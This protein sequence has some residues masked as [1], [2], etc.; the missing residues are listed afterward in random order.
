MTS[1]APW[2]QRLRNGLAPYAA[3]EPLAGRF[4]QRQLQAVQ[5]LTPLAMAANVLNV[6]IVAAAFRDHPRALWIAAWALL[7][8]VV[9]LR[10]VWGWWRVQRRAVR[11]SATPRALA[12]LTVHSALLAALWAPIPVLLFPGAAPD[13]Q[14]LV[15]TI[16][17]GMMCAGAFALATVPLAGL[18]YTALLGAAAVLA[19]ALSGLA[20]APAITMLLSIY[21]AIVMASV[22]STAR[23]FGARLVAE[24]EAERQN[25]VVGLLLRDFEENTSDVLWETGPD[26]RLRGTS[27]RLLQLLQQPAWQVQALPFTT[28]L[29]GLAGS[30]DD[31][32]RALAGWRRLLDGGQ[33][34]RDHALPV[35]VDGHSRCWSISAKPLLD[36]RGQPVGWRGVLADITEAHQAHRQLRWLAHN[37]T[38]TGLRNRHQ[39][40]SELQQLV[41]D[42]SPA[43]PAAAL[44]CVDLD[45][46][47]NVNDTLG[48]ATGDLLLKEV[49]R[50]MLAQVRRSDTVARMGGDEFAILQRGVAGVA[51]VE[52]FAA[53]LVDSLSAPYRVAGAQFS[54]GCSVGVTMVPRDG[55]A[56]DLVLN[57]ADQ[58]LYAAKDAGRGA[59]R[60]F[61]PE[62]AASTR[63]RLQIEQALHQAL[64]LGGLSL[65]YQ[66]QVAADDGRVIGF[67]A[68]LR[69]R[70]ATL[71]DV[72]PSEFVPVAEASGLMPQVGQ[73]V[74]EQACRDAATWPDALAV[75]INVSPVQVMAGDVAA[76]ALAAAQA[77]GLAP[78]RVEIEITE[79][80]FLQEGGGTTDAI[81]ALQRAGFRLALD[82]F[83]TGYSALAYL[84]RYPFHVLKIDRSFV[85]DVL[86]RGDAHAIVKMIVGL[87]RTLQLQ[88]V[89]EG[90]E[91]PAQAVLL[92]ELGCQVLQGYLVARPMPADQV[93][94]FLQR[95]SRQTP[96]PWVLAAPT[97]A[98]PLSAG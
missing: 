32:V 62:M 55:S 48:H 78:S 92:A 94:A 29:A 39:F 60:V 30:G 16:T 97:E 61:A 24:A 82:D 85:R 5:R 87:S 45:H 53:R 80:A 40:R 70:H 6:G 33:P 51:E 15:A 58:A 27:D 46:F 26:G 23:L 57:Q 84:R 79:S 90:V 13:E 11:S 69:W 67:E 35:E 25:E 31:A 47:K 71:G 10:G 14:I 20:L 18:V 83:G 89:A 42:A 66:P 49:S 76:H 54:V 68:L 7:V 41:A 43:A 59:V 72:T 2:T 22:W 3:D 75:S 88:T 77:A 19:L 9:A 96:R 52:Q 37:D 28:L 64:Q 17:T 34:F 98:T 21:A 1:P 12:R 95:W 44:L 74:L 36:E 86:T 93:Q 38:L 65:H 4:R 63:R 50:R 91:E 56:V 81:H 8:T 73:W